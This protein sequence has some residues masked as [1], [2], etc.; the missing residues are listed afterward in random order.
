MKW[1]NLTFGEVIFDEVT[2]VIRLTIFSVAKILQ[3]VAKNF[4]CNPWNYE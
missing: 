4:N 3:C 2:P 1:S